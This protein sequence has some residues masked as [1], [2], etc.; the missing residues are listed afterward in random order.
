MIVADTLS[1]L[2]MSEVDNGKKEIIDNR[3]EKQVEG[4]R[5]K[6]S[7]VVNGKE[8]WKFDNGEEREI[9][10]ENDRVLIIKQYHEMLG[11]RGKT[12]VYYELR[13]KFYWPGIKKQIEEVLKG[14]ETCQKYYRKTKGG[15]DFIQTSRYL[16]KVGDLI[17][18]RDEKCFVVVAIDYFIRLVWARVIE[19]KTASE[20]LMFLK[21]ICVGERPEEIITDNGKEF[22]NIQFKELC[23]DLGI[24]HRLVSVESHTS[25][26][27]VERIIRTLRES[28]LKNKKR[29]FKEKVEDAV[30]VYNNSY[31][32]DIQCSPIEAGK[33]QSG[34]VMIEN[35]PQ[36]NY[37]KMFRKGFR[38]KYTKGQKVRVAKRENLKERAKNCKGRFLDM[39]SIIEVCPGDSYLVLLENGKIRKRDIMT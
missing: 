19:R 29:S 24:R 18:F 8:V 35:G 22:S 9:L 23:K 6:H 38:E 32:M 33:D 1:R 13:K 28:I 37:A 14:C 21:S 26:G 20:I 36:G 34:K 17:E 10:K 7:K 2:Y 16:E 12:S 27:R 15:C 39:G 11:H 30:H 31:H 3:K 5:A 25:N 4:K